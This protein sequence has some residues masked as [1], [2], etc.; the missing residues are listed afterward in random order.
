MA[1]ARIDPFVPLTILHC[2]LLKL[3]AAYVLV[4][5]VTP[6]TAL[7]KIAI[8]PNA[9]RNNLESATVLTSLTPFTAS[10]TST[11]IRQTMFPIATNL[12][13]GKLIHSEI[14]NHF[15]CLLC[16]ISKRFGQV[17]S[18]ASEHRRN[19]ACKMSNLHQLRN[20]YAQPR[21]AL[22]GLMAVANAASQKTN[23]CHGT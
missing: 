7:P 20:E 1:S 16:Y 10:M 11:K 5:A 2:A 22:R 23:S 12:F 17:V 9:A 14:I 18:D 6:R 13:K 15:Q 3:F 19:I 8:D 21:F 4:I